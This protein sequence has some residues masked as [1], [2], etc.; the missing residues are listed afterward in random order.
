M[1][2]LDLS[3]D[4]DWAGH[5]CVIAAA[6][7]R[8]T[9]LPMQGAF[10]VLT[11]GGPGFLSHAF[12]RLPDGR[13]VDAGGIRQGYPLDT[14]EPRCEHDPDETVLGYL[15]VDTDERDPMLTEVRL[16]AIAETLR[17]THALAWVRRNLGPALEANGFPLRAGRY[18]RPPRHRGRRAAALRQVAAAAARASGTRA[19]A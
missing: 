11:S 7:A 17:E 19:A 4:R 5:C 6:I 16:H 1:T 9:G 18:R 8:L 12:C 13:I 10:E 15:V 2:P 3:A 14:L